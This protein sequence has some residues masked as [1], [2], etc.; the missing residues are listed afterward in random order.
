[1]ALAEF[2]LNTPVGALRLNVE[3]ETEEENAA[4]EQNAPE[5]P[6]QKPAEPFHP[7]KLSTALLKK[8]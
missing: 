7:A 6:E 1:M 3:I 8:S 2:L 4:Q 5:K